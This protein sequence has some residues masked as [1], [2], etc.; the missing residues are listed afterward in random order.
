MFISELSRWDI[1]YKADFN[2][3]PVA[4][5]GLLTSQFLQGF[6][7][8]EKRRFHEFLILRINRKW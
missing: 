2:A 6:H 5:C 8:R 4:L 1:V 3:L 7:R